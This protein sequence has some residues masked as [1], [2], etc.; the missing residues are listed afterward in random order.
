M[1]D[2]F[3]FVTWF[4]SPSSEIR[5]EGIFR[6]DGNGLKGPLDDMNYNDT[7]VMSMMSVSVEWTRLPN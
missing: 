7:R 3:F 4:P 2:E 6:R 1:N 5:D